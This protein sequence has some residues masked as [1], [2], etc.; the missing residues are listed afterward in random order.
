MQ[1]LH[2]RRRTAK[3][4]E[5]RSLTCVPASYRCPPGGHGRPPAAV[6]PKLTVKLDRDEPVYT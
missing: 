6:G 4:L 2:D 1:L 3:L 5:S